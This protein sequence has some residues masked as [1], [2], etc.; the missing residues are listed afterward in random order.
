MRTRFNQMHIIRWRVTINPSI[1][2]S[3]KLVFTNTTAPIVGDS[4]FKDDRSASIHGV[5]ARRQHRLHEQ[6]ADRNPIE[7]GGKF[8]VPGDFRGGGEKGAEVYFISA[9][10][11][12][13]AG[14]P[15][16]SAKRTRRLIASGARSAV[17]SSDRDVVFRRPTATL[18][19][20]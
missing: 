18:G 4:T 7:P 16:S 1:T 6:N 14:A 19:I 15:T 13:P 20:G 9:A 10:Q 8:T 12:P 3:F 17:Q 2:Q 5:A 11:P